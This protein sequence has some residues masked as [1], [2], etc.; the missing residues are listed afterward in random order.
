M[1]IIDLKKG[2]KNKTLDDSFIIFKYED[3]PFIATQYINAISEFKNRPIVYVDSFDDI[4]IDIFSSDKSLYVMH[5]NKIEKNIFSQSLNN[6]IIV[7][8]DIDKDLISNI[9]KYIVDIPK[10]ETWQIKSYV[11]NNLPGLS[12]E[13]INWLIDIT[14]DVYRL[15]NEMD[16]IK[17]FNKK[18]QQ[19]IFKLLNEEDSYSD[20]NSHTI[21]NLTNAITNRDIKTAR[22]ILEVID[23]MN[24][25]SMAVLTILYK[26]FKNIINIQ[27]SSNPTPESTGMNPKQFHAIKYQVG[28][29]SNSQLVYIFDVLTTIDYQLK[30]GVI[31]SDKVIDYILINVF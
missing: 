24:I 18:D 8:K 26:S 21:F 3:V 11:Q 25:E 13:E 9:K 4:A 28:K 31:P 29:F 19:K 30:T 14:K 17:I 20:L 23:N 6:K 5:I 1:N 22:S 7:C 12:S 15:S 2:I 16:K 10:L 27:M